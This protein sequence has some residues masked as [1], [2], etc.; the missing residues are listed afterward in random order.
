MEIESDFNQR[1]RW[2]LFDDSTIT[3]YESSEKYM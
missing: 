3:E 2:I 1:N